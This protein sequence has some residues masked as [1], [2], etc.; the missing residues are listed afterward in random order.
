VERS[1][2]DA[3]KKLHSFTV[4]LVS[5]RRTSRPQANL[6]ELVVEARRCDSGFLIL[7]SGSGSKRDRRGPR[8]PGQRSAQEG[9]RSPISI[10][11]RWCKE[12][13][14]DPDQQTPWRTASSATPAR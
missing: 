5:A 14:A 10:V 2:L 11:A 7:L 13:A 12:A 3:F 8:S 1:R 9:P 6:V 4:P